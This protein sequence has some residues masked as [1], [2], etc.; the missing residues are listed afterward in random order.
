MKPGIPGR[1]TYSSKEI[2]IMDSFAGPSRTYRPV[3]PDRL[4]QSDLKIALQSAFA[5]G[6][7]LGLPAGLFFWLIILQRSAPSTQMDR[8]V[9]FLQDYAVPPVLLE[10]LGA[11]GWG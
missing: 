1:C 5:A 4:S 10:M 6:L 2:S 3:T 7:C 11:F 8:L 9:H